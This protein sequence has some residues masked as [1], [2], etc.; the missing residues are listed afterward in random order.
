MIEL[1]DVIQKIPLALVIREGEN[2]I[3]AN[4]EAKKI[5]L[6]SLDLANKEKIVVDKKVYKLLY[7]RFK[8]YD[9]FIAFEY[10][11]EQKLSD[12]LHAYERFF[13]SGKDFF[14][15]LDE[16]GRFLDVNQTYEVVGYHREELLGKTSRIISFDDQIETLRENFRRVLSGETVRFIFKARTATGEAKFIEVLEWPRIVD[17]K[18]I[19]SEG[20]ARD[21]TERFLLQQ[22]LEKM[23]RALQ[24][25]TQV[26]QQIFKE[27]DEYALLQKIWSILKSYG[28]RSYIW[29]NKQ[30]KFVDAIPNASE[31]PAFKNPEL[32]YETCNCERSKGKSLIIP[33]T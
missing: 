11:E 29:I 9:L 8:N 17:G 5:G 19:G 13:K 21:I 3:Y 25:L 2:L 15:I 12:A 16:K 14:F 30:N 18:I 31:C 23:N 1:H 10:T 22:Q 7:T 24:I 27:R 26:N 4:D 6:D 32:R 28:I 20:V 33:L